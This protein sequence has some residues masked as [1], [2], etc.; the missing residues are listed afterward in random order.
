MD[1]QR[2][3]LGTLIAILIRLGTPLWGLEKQIL[4]GVQISKKLF[5]AEALSREA[6]NESTLE[7][8]IAVLSHL[9]TT[10]SYQ[11]VVSHTITS[12]KVGHI[13]KIEFACDDYTKAVW[14]LTIA[15]KIVW[16][17]KYLPSASTLTWSDLKVRGGT[18]TKVEVKSDDAS[19]FT[20]WG[21][22]TG[23]E[24]S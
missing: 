12:G 16:S 2:A 6:G 24:T 13:N 9:E 18:V 22:I 4:D 1:I 7:D 20:A 17:D 19:A 15:G 14:R 23:K 8:P 11:D 21:D 5:L 3:I 10:G